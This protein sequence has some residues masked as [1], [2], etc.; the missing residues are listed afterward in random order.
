MP[1]W[2]HCHVNNILCHQISVEQKYYLDMMHALQLPSDTSCKDIVFALFLHGLYTEQF[3][4]CVCTALVQRCDNVRSFFVPI[5]L[6]AA[7]NVLKL[8]PKRAHAGSA[9]PLSGSTYRLVSADKAGQFVLD[10]DVTLLPGTTGLLFHQHLVEKLDGERVIMF[11]LIALCPWYIYPDRTLTDALPYTNVVPNH[12]G[13]SFDREFLKTLRE[14][15]TLPLHCAVFMSDSAQRTELLPEQMASFCLRWNLRRITP[16]S[17]RHS[18]FNSVMGIAQDDADE[19]ALHLTGR[20]FKFFRAQCAA[21]LLFG[22]AA[23]LDNV[24]RLLRVPELKDRHRRWIVKQLSDAFQFYVK[25]FVTDA[26]LAAQLHFV[27]TLVYPL[28][29]GIVQA[30]CGNA[31]AAVLLSEAEEYILDMDFFALSSAGAGMPLSKLLGRGSAVCS[32]IRGRLLLK[33]QGAIEFGLACVERQLQC[34]A[35]FHNRLFPHGV[36]LEA[37]DYCPFDINELPLSANRYSP[38]RTGKYDDAVFNSREHA[39]LRGRSF[40]DV[41]LQ[42]AGLSAVPPQV[43]SCNLARLFGTTQ[44]PEE[45]NTR[46][47][48]LMSR[49]SNSAAELR[50]LVQSTSSIDSSSTAQVC[51]IEDIGEK[52]LRGDAM[53]LCARII[54]KQVV[55]GEKLGNDAANHYYR[56]LRSFELQHAQVRDHMVS[57]IADD[58]ERTAFAQKIDTKVAAFAE[59]SRLFSAKRLEEHKFMTKD[60]A[61]ENSSYMLSCYKLCADTTKEHACPYARLSEQALRSVLPP[62]PDDTLQHI[63]QLCKEGK[64]TWACGEEFRAHRPNAPRYSTIRRPSSYVAAALQLDN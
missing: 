17:G 26:S 35:E 15:C 14:K 64:Y 50:S 46:R 27:C 11:T 37:G 12:I 54:A 48:L 36:N 8:V 51:D 20:S 19:L 31:A 28:L 45:N 9:A 29:H 30:K 41:A 4:E 3:G 18:L 24:D 22:N 47:G 21:S 16:N 57:R 40:P 55:A 6:P 13:H 44:T 10:Q 39:M 63:L 58:F 52:L 32:M 34:M 42:R 5:L 59:R 1:Q 62:L 23:L 49:S 2:Q 60:D 38:T 53:P 7:H 43:A 25:R 61:I 33:L 56:M